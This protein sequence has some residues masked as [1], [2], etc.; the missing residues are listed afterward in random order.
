VC[1]PPF[2]AN[3]SIALRDPVAGTGTSETY[4]GLQRPIR[5]ANHLE[6]TVFVDQESH[7]RQRISLPD[8]HFSRLQDPGRPFGE[9]I[10]ATLPGRT[11]HETLIDLSADP[12]E[13]QFWSVAGLSEQAREGRVGTLMAIQLSS[14]RAPFRGLL[15]IE[16][17][18]DES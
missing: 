11:A 16:E 13:R 3:D 15:L 8:S 9:Q 4:E 7:F 6:R 10:T 5:L 1:F 17:R 12:C 18:G 14:P 2:N